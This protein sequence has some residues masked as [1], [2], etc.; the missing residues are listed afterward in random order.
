MEN[1]VSD[2]RVSDHQKS[3]LDEKFNIKFSFLCKLFEKMVGNK[4]KMK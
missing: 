2:L 4:N 3:M 1:N